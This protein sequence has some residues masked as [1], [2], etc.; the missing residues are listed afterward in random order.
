VFFVVRDG[1]TGNNYNSLL[2]FHNGT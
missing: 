1:R 2:T